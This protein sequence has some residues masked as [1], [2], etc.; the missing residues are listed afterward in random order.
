MPLGKQ[1]K[2]SGLSGVELTIALN[3]LDNLNEEGSEARGDAA[4][5]DEL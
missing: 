4:D 2:K 5:S 1:R 3:A